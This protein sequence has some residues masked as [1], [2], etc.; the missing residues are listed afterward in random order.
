MTKKNL[1]ASV[2]G[3]QIITVHPNVHNFIYTTDGIAIAFIS[4]KTRIFY[5]GSTFPTRIYVMFDAI[6]FVRLEHL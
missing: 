4:S 1:E 5:S 3:I 6:L 2:I